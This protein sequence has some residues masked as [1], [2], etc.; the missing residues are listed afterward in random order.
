MLNI[1]LDS[2][3]LQSAS[4]WMLQVA[5]PWV[6]GFIILGVVILVVINIRNRRNNPH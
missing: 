2:G 6:V 5:A 1:L 4:D 3:Q